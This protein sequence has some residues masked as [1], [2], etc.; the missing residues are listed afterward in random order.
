MILGNWVK[1]LSTACLSN[2]LLESRHTLQIGYSYWTWKFFSF[3]FSVLLLATFIYVRTH[4]FVRKENLSCLL[5]AIA[6]ISNFWQ[7]KKRTQKKMIYVE[8]FTD[9]VHVIINNNDCAETLIIWQT[10][11]IM[12]R[13]PLHEKVWLKHSIRN[14][15][16]SSV[17]KK[18]WSVN[19]KGPFVMT[20]RS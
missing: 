12:K 2:Y 6:H 1:I 7:Q 11:V 8:G 10:F 16:F 15:K 5:K 9:F 14:I 19:L 13:N 20:K 18:C 3:F 4:I 17:H